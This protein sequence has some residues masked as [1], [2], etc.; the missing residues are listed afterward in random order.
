MNIL[1]SHEIKNKVTNYYWT[2]TNLLHYFLLSLFLY[3]GK[4][5]HQFCSVIFII[6]RI[7]VT[8]FILQNVYIHTFQLRNIFKAVVKK[9]NLYFK[10]HLAKVEY[11]RW[12]RN[13]I[14][15]VTFIIICNI[16]IICNMI[17]VHVTAL[18][19]PP[20]RYQSIVLNEIWRQFHQKF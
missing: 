20:T 1:F 8:V 19:K 13:T 5:C 4:F 16:I 11:I 6:R 10:G 12:V 18:A 7:W 14:C 9:N 17:H 3:S 2:Q 15:N